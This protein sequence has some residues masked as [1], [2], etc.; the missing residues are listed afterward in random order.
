MMNIEINNFINGP[1][2]NNTY[3]LFD[4]I[5]KN[6]VVIDP[7][8]DT[9]SLISCIEKKKLFLRQIW[10]THAHFD[11]TIGIKDL[12]SRFA[13]PIDIALHPDDLDLW[14]SGGGGRHFNLPSITNPPPTL[15]LSDSQILELGET[16][17][18]ILHTPGHSPGSVVYYCAE[19]KKAFCGD[20]IFKGSVGRTD[21]PDGNYKQLIHSIETKILTLPS[22]TIL[23]P[24][25]GPETSVFIESTT[26]PFL[27]F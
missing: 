13:H 10:I 14:N 17:W 12:L 27:A 16:R 3:L 6:A 19:L 1:L 4:P 8:L 7:S 5:T 2:K 15:L 25:H 21:L 22:D 26:N 11:H 20:L 23:Y 18:Q 24:G 9:Q